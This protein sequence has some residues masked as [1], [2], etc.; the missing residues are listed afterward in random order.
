MSLFVGSGRR[1]CGRQNFLFTFVVRIPELCT[2]ITSLDIPSL[3]TGSAFGLV[4]EQNKLCSERSEA[5]PVQGKDGWP[6][7]RKYDL[8]ANRSGIETTKVKKKL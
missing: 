6:K 2:Q 3:L 4:P 1:R 5:E 7:A 8:C